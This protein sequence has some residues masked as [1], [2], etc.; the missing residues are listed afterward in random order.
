[1]RILKLF[2]LFKLILFVSLTDCVQHANNN[3]EH[4]E[5]SKDDQIHPLH[6]F[7]CSRYY[8]I[9][10]VNGEKTLLSILKAIMKF[11]ISSEKSET[12]STEEIRWHSINKLFLPLPQWRRAQTA[13]LYCEKELGIEKGNM[14]KCLNELF[15]DFNQ[16]RGHHKSKLLELLIDER[17]KSLAERLYNTLYEEENSLYKGDNDPTDFDILFDIILARPVFELKQIIEM[18]GKIA[19][20]KLEMRLHYKK[21]LAKKQ[22]ENVEMWDILINRIE[23]VQNNLNFDED[24][25]KK[26]SEHTISL[27]NNINNIND[28]GRFKSKDELLLLTSSLEVVLR[29][30][31]FKKESAVNFGKKFK[32]C[33]VNIFNEKS[34]INSSDKNSIKFPEYMKRML[35]ITGL[36]GEEQYNIDIVDRIIDYIENDKYEELLSLVVI[37]HGSDFVEIAKILKEKITN[38]NLELKIIKND[39]MGLYSFFEYILSEE[40]ENENVEENEN[41][42]E[43]SDYSEEMEN[44]YLSSNL[45]CL[46]PT[47]EEYKKDVELGNL[48]YEHNASFQRKDWPQLENICTKLKIFGQEINMLEYSDDKIKKRNDFATVGEWKN[49]K[50]ENSVSKRIE[51]LKKGCLTLNEMINDKPDFECSRYYPSNYGEKSLFTILQSIQILSDYNSRWELL[52]K[53]FLPLPQWHRAET[54]ELY[55][56]KVFNI[57]NGDM[58][59]CLNELFKDFNQQR[60]HHK[61]KLLELLIDERS[62][63]LAERLYYTLNIAD[64]TDFD[65]LYDI[66]LARPK[67]ELKQIIK[68][69]DI[70]LLEQDKMEYKKFPKDSISILE[71]CLHN[72]KYLAKKEKESVDVF[73]IL[74]NRIGSVENN[75]FFDINFKNISSRITQL[76][77]NPSE[78]NKSKLLTVA[79]RELLINFEFES[80][81]VV[82]FSKELVN[83]CGKNF[84]NNQSNGEGNEGT[85][86]GSIILPEYMKRMLVITGFA[87]KGR[88]NQEIANRIVYYNENGKYQE[89]LSLVLI[90]YGNDLLKIIYILKEKSEE[91]EKKEKELEDELLDLSLKDVEENNKIAKEKEDKLKE[92]KLKK[93]E[94]L[95]EI[96]LRM[97]TNRKRKIQ[98]LN[99]MEEL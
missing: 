48:E 10:G 26:I 51:K 27:C 83:K 61:S 25:F 72:K 13:L 14:K 43:W 85:S 79:F 76:C 22:N 39:V 45:K 57:E 5:S 11:E 64:S 86:N 17:S 12:N 21:R 28:E 29:S 60:G 88:Y 41:N 19:I 73:D 9:V 49:G 55:C 91:Y 32:K 38:E 23:S 50:G 65:T 33:G 40:F 54:A 95:N 92:L 47:E 94:I 1:M 8:P 7:E 59:K 74:I 3:A 75:I 70:V 42:D 18:Y 81:N 62:K 63:S 34:S 78:D 6:L 66:I 46:L 68:M 56:R 77:E 16:Q 44:E 4:S 52:N 30:F 69:Y 2:V 84:L 98:E 90:H 99:N 20:S 67:F 37:H 87:G 89:L 53:L 80:E 93:E 36:V 96:K 58:K 24:E 31:E 35:I 71:R 97:K 82:M 15:K